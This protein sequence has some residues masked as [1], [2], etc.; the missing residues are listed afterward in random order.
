MA[1]WRKVGDDRHTTKIDG[2]L[3]TVEVWI[4]A[5][6]VYRGKDGP[7][8]ADCQTFAEAKAWVEAQAL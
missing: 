1:R 2:V 7:C 8:V 4:D 6:R 5:V 3:Y